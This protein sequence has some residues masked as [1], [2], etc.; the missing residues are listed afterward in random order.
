MAE[1]AAYS[2]DKLSIRKLKS[3][4]GTRGVS[5]RGCF[6]KHEIVAARA[7]VRP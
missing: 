5:L 4:A 7:S 2:F 3:L 1:P 6:E